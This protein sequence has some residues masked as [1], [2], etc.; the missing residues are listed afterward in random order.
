MESSR[1]KAP[2]RSKRGR[3]DARDVPRRPESGAAGGRADDRRA[4]AR[5]RRRGLGQDARAH[6][7]HRASARR[8]RREAARDPR[9][10]VHE[11]G[12][13]RDARAGRGSRRA[14]GAR[15]VGD[16]V[17]RRLRPHPAPRGA[18][19]RLPLELHD[20]RH[21]RPAAAHE[22][23]PRGSRARPEALH[24]ARHPL[25]DLEREEPADRPRRLRE[26]RRELLRPD[27]RRRLQALP[28][29][30]VQLERRR[31]RRHALSHR[32][33][34]RALPRGAGEV[35]DRVPLPARRR[36]PGHEPR[37][38]PVPAAAGRE[39]LERLRRGRSGPV[40]LRVPRRR[41][42]QRARVRARLPGREDDRARAELPLD[43][44]DPRG[45]ERR[46]L[47]QPRAQAEEPLVGARRRRSG[48]RRRGG[49]R[50]LRGALRRRRDRAARRGGLQ[51]QRDRR[52][53][54]DERAEPRARGR[55]RPPG[56][57]V[58]G[59]RRPALLRARGDQ[60][61]RRVSPGDRQ[62]VRRGVA[63]ADREPAAPRDRRLDAS[64]S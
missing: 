52:L 58:P 36:V 11:Q 41:H 26:P 40:D 13:R 7:P 22:A 37:A 62:P 20:L 33:R 47:A 64:R 3:D 12:R 34:A 16:D 18:A 1:Q 43:E 32:R 53:L 28:D 44:L 30:D 54:P 9:D 6:A 31:L 46:H 61:S 23:V 17:P 27:R 57:R 63:P 60:G 50:A 59:D 56:R 24:A 2:L 55:A 49:G 45:R 25:A 39:A 5:D 14:A 42:P 19:A 21:R 4:G 48:A 10:H 51:R 29:E 38:V 8:G 35:A 15:R